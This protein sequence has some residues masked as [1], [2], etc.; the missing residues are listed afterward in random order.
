MQTQN[1]P[2]VKERVIA[3]FGG[4]QRVADAANVSRQAV[5]Q[6]KERIPAKHQ[7]DLL[8]AARARGIDLRPE[9]FFDMPS[10]AA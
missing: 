10:E 6:W 9:D 3:K 4:V 7:N 1:Q 5:W 8:V 2:S